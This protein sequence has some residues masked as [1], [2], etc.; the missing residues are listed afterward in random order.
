M[1]P[2]LCHPT[3]ATLSTPLFFFVAPFSHCAA[4]VDPISWLQPASIGIA[5]AMIPESFRFLLPI[6]PLHRTKYYGCAPCTTR[7]QTVCNAVHSP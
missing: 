2:C 7:R 4:N 5:H 1:P 3:H 6:S